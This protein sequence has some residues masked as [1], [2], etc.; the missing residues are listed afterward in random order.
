[1]SWNIP[2]FHPEALQEHF[3]IFMKEQVKKIEPVTPDRPLLLAVSGGL[4]SMALLHLTL[5]LNIPF[6]V[7]HVNFSLRDEESDQDELFVRNT[8]EAL[9][10]PV[11]IKKFDTIYEAK[12]LKKGIQE[13]ARILRYEWMLTPIQQ[14]KAAAL[15]TAHHADDHVETALMHY[16][17]GAGLNGLQ[18]I[19]T[20]NKGIL[21]PL[22]SY[23]KQ[24]LKDY[25]LYHHGSW[26]EDSSN[27]T[28][29][30]TRNF[31]RHRVWPV[32]E[33]VF[34]TV[35]NNIRQ[36]LTYYREAALLLKESTD[37]LYRRY[38]QPVGNASGKVEELPEFKFPCTPLKKHPAVGTVLFEWLQ[39]YGFRSAQITDLIHL[40]DAQSGKWI[41]AA[42][43]MFKIYRFGKWVYVLRHAPET[44]SVLHFIEEED[45]ENGLALQVGH[46]IFQWKKAESPGLLL[47]QAQKA[48]SH[49]VYLN[50]E[51]MQFPIVIRSAQPGDYLYPLG[52]GKKKKVAR[53]LIDEKVPSFKKA[54]IPLIEIGKKIAWVSGVRMDQ[55]FAIHPKSKSALYIKMLD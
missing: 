48:S 9:Q 1:M 14:N 49:E 38:A 5:Q 53:L 23:T 4:D 29:K 45:L 54:S 16:F 35:K 2:S 40:L 15:L 37:R 27:L 3:R 47:A 10:V 39:K 13:T 32:V 24:E 42:D 34:P 55:R 19:A 8:C 51:A 21:R 28:D 6:Q 46:L 22:L 36:H 50:G 11:S 52:L 44:P 18:G 12:K 7:L 43:G 31:F 25:L 20:W 41:A 30:Y 17:R 26:R 33:E